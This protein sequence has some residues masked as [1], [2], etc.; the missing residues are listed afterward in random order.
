MTWRAL[1]WPVARS[2]LVVLAVSALGCARQPPPLPPVPAGRP[3]VGGQPAEEARRPVPQPAG[4]SGDPTSGVPAPNL[5][6]PA[7][8]D[9][10]VGSP[11][12]RDQVIQERVAWWIEYW[13]TRSR[14]PFQ[15]GL[16]RMGSYED[17]IAAELAR[18]DLP[19]SL[20]YL[21]LIEA[22]YYPGAVSPVGAAGL[23]QFMPRTAQW[24]GLEVNA[25]LDE[26]FDPVAAT[27]V[28]LDYIVDLKEQFESWFLTLAAYNAGP[29]RVEAAIRRHGG[30]RPRTDALFTRIRSRLPSE[31]RDFVPKYLAA[32]QLASSLSDYGIPDPPKAPPLRFDVVNVE[33]AASMDV[34]ARASGADEED[35]RRLNPHLRVGITPAGASTPVRLPEG[36]SEGFGERFALIPPR[37]RVTRHI[38]SAGENPWTIA[39]SYGMSVD[40]LLAANPNVEPRRLQIGASLVI[41]FADHTAPA[42]VD[43]LANLPPD[44][45]AGNDARLS[46]ARQRVGGSHVVVRGDSLW[47]IARLYGV[48]LARLRAHNRLGDDVLLQPGDT[49]WIPAAR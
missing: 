32:V 26:R 7:D 39:R 16:S 31:T 28:A 20:L 19:S 49:I 2:G 45:P 41:P 23:W 43:R 36:R 27:P 15:R 11:T 14:A 6:R 24:L 4:R 1:R 25:V 42:A 44:A 30:G 48:D 29:G 5:A 8:V 40:E 21:P 22:N 34:I 17:L 13:R 12:S 35:V 37:E 18:R 3:A 10:I 33:G 46:A 9:P 47:L 38:V